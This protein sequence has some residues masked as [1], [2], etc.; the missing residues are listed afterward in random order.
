MEPSTAPFEQFD[1]E[2]FGVPF[3]VIPERD[4][5]DASDGDDAPDEEKFKIPF[6][7]IPERDEKTP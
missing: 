2:K 7:V 6:G 1:K 4:E 3:G 5:K